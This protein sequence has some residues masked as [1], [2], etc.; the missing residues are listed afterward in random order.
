[1]VKL[2]TGWK[3][4]DIH[5]SKFVNKKINCLDIGSF[6]GDS[7]CWML[8]NIC[9][10][11]Y[12]RVY[13]VDTWE[14]SPEYNSEVKFD[15]IEKE[16]DENVLKTGNSEKNV[17]MKMTSMNALIKLK[18]EN[19]IIFDFI[20]I[21][22]SHEAK[23]VLTDAILSWEILNEE[24]IL[25]FDD[26]KWD[27]LNEEYFKP[28]I[29]IDSFVSIYKN[30]LEVLYV[31]YQ[32][33]IKKIN[34]TQ[35]KKPELAEE[36]KL[37]DKLQ[38]F[39]L[40]ENKIEINENNKDDI[41]FKLD[42]VKYDEKYLKMINNIERL[43][44]FF[45]EKK[46]LDYFEYS[47]KYKN[48]SEILLKNTKLTLENITLIE[49][50]I[51]L[52]KYIKNGMNIYINRYD[53]SEDKIE[54]IK[55]Y[56]N[57]NDV[58]YK[59]D[60]SIIKSENK[61]NN[62]IIINKKFDLIFF[63]LVKFTDENIKYNKIYHLFNLM[64]ALN[65]QKINGTTIHLINYKAE[66]LLMNQIIFIFKKYYRNII[67]QTKPAHLYSRY[68]YIILEGFIGISDNE[69]NNINKLIINII[70][71]YDENINSIIKNNYNNQLFNEF[72]NNKLLNLYNYIN[73][74][75]NIYKLENQK[76]IN[77]MKQILFQK[78][79]KKIINNIF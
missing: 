45:E 67:F 48:I 8:N 61:Y 10:N 27:K 47:N 19:L 58:H 43:I 72:Y 35:I 32:Y 54:I 13:S 11:P 71:N 21:D 59:L 57:I 2:N 62:I 73:I 34:I 36:Y 60:N 14:G 53:I 37:L 77:K 41:K 4:W 30:Q 79:L 1:M 46:F 22:A 20:F 74:L 64:S 7:T 33:I 68:Y 75:Y 16:F 66:L 17:K 40:Y 50:Y 31:G 39:K 6:K 38:Y 42:I 28:K 49:K 24:G 56:F 15:K 65:I 44:N 25:I 69:L 3:N 5:L 55:K 29:A 63:G 70:I 26:Y 12:S 18:Q 76:I 9:Q 51:I 23:N 52:S 78:S